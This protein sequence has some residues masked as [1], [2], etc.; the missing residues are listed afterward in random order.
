MKKVVLVSLLFSS[1]VGSQAYAYYPVEAEELTA[2]YHRIEHGEVNSAVRE[3]E[4]L[5]DTD[6]YNADVWS[7]LG[8]AK[9]KSGDL[10]GSESAYKQALRLEPNHKAALSYQ[11]ELFIRQGKRAQAQENLRQL[12][13]LCKQQAEQECKELH[14]LDTAL[15][16]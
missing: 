10:I 5:S 13:L 3:L 12:Q 4:A 11:G 1:F 14:A 6:V 2:L 16:R 15:K 7:L 8:Y 9:R